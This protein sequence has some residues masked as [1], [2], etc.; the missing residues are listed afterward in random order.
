MNIKEEFEHNLDT[1]LDQL[2][3]NVV[4]NRNPLSIEFHRAEFYAKIM[5]MFFK[6]QNYKIPEATPEE[7]EKLVEMVKVIKKLNQKIN[8]P[9]KEKLLKPL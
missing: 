4:Y 2:L 9:K 5:S 6:S 1:L 3:R 8:P 7:K